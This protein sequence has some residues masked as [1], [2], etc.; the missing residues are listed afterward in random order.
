VRLRQRH[1]TNDLETRGRVVAVVESEHRITPRGWQNLNSLADPP[2]ADDTALA[3][4]VVR[5]R[6]ACRSVR[7]PP[8]VVVE[9]NR[10]SSPPA[11]KELPAM[12]VEANPRFRPDALRPHLQVF[13]RAANRADSK[14]RLGKWATM[15]STG[16]A[17][18]FKEQELLP[19]FLSDTVG[20]L[21]QRA[22]GHATGGQRGAFPD[23]LSHQV[24]RQ[25]RD[26]CQATLLA[27]D[28]RS[29]TKR[30]AQSG[31]TTPRM[32]RLLRIWRTTHQRRNPCV[33]GVFANRWE[34]RLGDE[35]L[36]PPTSTV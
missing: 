23:A 13:A 7:L 28:R 11:W 18:T 17:D 5:H 34:S 31:A 2:R 1:S 9:R 10:S 21:L 8:I 29:L 32:E 25:L 4:V 24:A 15:D 30:D 6:E 16:R 20:C 33:S 22:W 26:A 3:E 19:D 35:G 14:A 36:E 27:S 12:P